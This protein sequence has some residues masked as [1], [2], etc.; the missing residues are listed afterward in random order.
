MRIYTPGARHIPHFPERDNMAPHPGLGC[1][2]SKR[3]V[4][5]SRNRRIIMGWS[6]ASSQPIAVKGFRRERH[7]AVRT[8]GVDLGKS[9]FHRAGCYPRPPA[10]TVLNRFQSFLKHSAQDVFQRAVYEEVSYYRGRGNYSHSLALDV[11]TTVSC[12]ISPE[13]IK[14]VNPAMGLQ[15]DFTQV[16]G[17]WWSGASHCG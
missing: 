17:L 6:A 14:I 15:V 11:N 3:W 5:C 8:I 16:V 13:C 1:S 10:E 2:A 12:F 4:Q 9:L 7:I